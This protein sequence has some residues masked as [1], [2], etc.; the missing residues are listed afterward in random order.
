VFLTKYCSSDQFKEENVGEEFGMD[1]EEKRISE[2]M[3]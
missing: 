3:G 1:E 2:L